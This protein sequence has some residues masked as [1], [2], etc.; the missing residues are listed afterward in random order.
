MVFVSFLYDQE[1]VWQ[2]D[3]NKDILAGLR[4][5]GQDPVGDCS[6]KGTCGKCKARLISGALSPITEVEEE[7]LSVNER[8]TGFFLMCQRHSLSDRLVI[9]APM[10]EGIALEEIPAS[11]DIEFTP[12][13]GYGVVIDIGTTSLAAQIVD[14]QSGKVLK[15]ASLGNAQRS[16]GADVISRIEY[17]AENGEEGLSGLQ[18]AVLCALNNLL[19]GLCERA[20]VVPKDIKEVVLAGNTVMSHLFLGIDPESLGHYPFEPKFKAAPELIAKM[21]GLNVNPFAKVRLLPNI[22]GYVGGDTVGVLLAENLAV[23]K[24]KVLAVDIGTNGEIMLAVDGKILVASTAAGPAFEGMQIQM[25]MRGVPGAISDVKYNEDVEQI[26]CS[27]IGSEPA[28]GI[29]GSGLIAA[30]SAFLE[31][32]IVEKGGRF[33]YPDDLPAHLA[34]RLQKGSRGMEFVL[35]LPGEHDALKPVVLTQKDIR[36]IQLAKGAMA[37]G[38]EILLKNAGLTVNDLDEIVLAGAFGSHID[39]Q[40][41]IN[42]GLLPDVPV[43]KIKAIGNGALAGAKKALLSAEEWAKALRIGETAQHIDLSTDDDFQKIFMKNM[44]F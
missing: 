7:V 24:G 32:G 23:K 4:E 19:K 41:A 36:E 27:V 16:F 5:A 33:A 25:G 12:R 21:A 2:I 22:A 40:A 11:E 20:E 1:V 28:V 15:N 10:R 34:R 14:L 42:I 17:V 8:A 44:S 39:A 43:A 35:V 31:G 38:I 26:A 30:A 29:C 3:D 18:N 9:D 37:A 13:E 6:G